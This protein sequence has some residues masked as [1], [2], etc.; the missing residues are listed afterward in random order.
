V[1]SLNVLNVVEYLRVAQTGWRASE[2]RQD[3]HVISRCLV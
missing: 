1:A 2:V 3:R